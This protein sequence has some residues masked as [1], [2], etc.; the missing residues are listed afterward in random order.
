MSTVGQ[1][2][3]AALLDRLASLL[4]RPRADVSVGIGD[5]A[6]VLA[7]A[8]ALVAT[9]DSVVAGIDW[10]PRKTPRRAVGHRAVAVNLSDLAAMGAR[11]AHLLLALELPDALPLH[12]LLSSVEGALAL[13]DEHGAAVVGGDIGMG[14]GPERW[15]VTAMGTMQGEPLLRSAARPGDRL[16]LV[17]QVGAASVGLAAL[18]DE[19]APA[20]LQTCIDAH[21]WPRPQVGAGLALAGC[22]QRVAAM[23]VSDGLWLDGSRLAAASGV[24]LKMTL[25]E[26]TWLTAEVDAFC[27]DAGL[28][29]RRACASGGDD[30]ALLVAAPDGLDVAAVVGTRAEPVGQVNASAGQV[31]MSIAGL[32]LSG[33]RT[34]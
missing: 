19:V 10:L 12:A 18:I 2:G 29:W 4:S 17:G 22:G 1:L 31:L 30:Y 7:T 16:W 8:G 20:G 26:P 6:A 24:G 33:P 13:A 5:D 25:P 32:P 28:D 23:D 11:P 27:R 9:V 3:E 34:G 21:L 14:V 15:A